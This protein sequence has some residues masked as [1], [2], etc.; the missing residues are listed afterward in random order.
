MLFCLYVHRITDVQWSITNRLWQK[1]H[2]WSRDRVHVYVLHRDLWIEE[3][4]TKFK[5]QVITHIWY[6]AVTEIW[7]LLLETGSISLNHDNWNLCI[8]ESCRQGLFLCVISFYGILSLVFSHF[9]FSAIMTS[10]TSHIKRTPWSPLFILLQCVYDVSW[11]RFEEKK[12]HYWEKSVK[13]LPLE[14]G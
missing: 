3:L 12:H 5:L 13:Y 7:T 4:A 14:S 9:S 11:D 1:C 10:A 2:G 6:I 8:L